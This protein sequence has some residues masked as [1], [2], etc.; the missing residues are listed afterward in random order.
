MPQCTLPDTYAQCP[1]P[2][3]QCPVPAFYRS[4]KRQ[5]LLERKRKVSAPVV[6][7]LLPLSADVDTDRLYSSLLTACESAGRGA[8]DAGDGMDLGGWQLQKLWQQLAALE[9]Q[10]DACAC[11]MHVWRGSTGW[12]AAQHLVCCFLQHAV[13]MYIHRAPRPSCRLSLTASWC[14]CA[15][16]ELPPAAPLGLQTVAVAGRSRLRVTLVPPPT[17]REDLLQ[18]GRARCRAR[19]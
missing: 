6:V 16:E 5:E 12:A 14:C 10:H 2:N 7:A 4:Q 9:Q 18:V 13:W 1:M 19:C 15:A 11:Y 17:D 3:A 8:G